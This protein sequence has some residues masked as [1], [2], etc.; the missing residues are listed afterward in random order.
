[1]LFRSYFK[2]A[3]VNNDNQIIR[4]GYIDKAI[5]DLEKAELGLRERNEI[6]DLRVTLS[7]LSEV[8]YY[9]E[10]YQ[11]S[12]TYYKEATALKDTI[13]NIE[14]KKKIAEL[15]AVK[16]LEIKEKENEGL[17]NLSLLQESE[18]KRRN[19]ELINLNNL[20]KIQQLEIEKKNFDIKTKNN[21]LRLLEKDK[22][23]K[24]LEIVR[25]D[26]KAKESQTQIELLNKTLE[27]NT[28][29]RLFMAI[30]IILFAILVILLFIFFRRKKKA[31][32][33]LKDK[34]AQIEDANIE[35]ERMNEDLIERG[36]EL[37]EANSLL[38][39]QR[40]E[41][42]KYS[43]E[44]E[45]MVDDRTQ[46]LVYAMNE[47]EKANKL[48]T[49]IIAN[50]NHEIRTPLNFIKGSAALINV[51]IKNELSNPDVDDTLSSL[52][53]GVSRLTTTLE[54]FTDLSALKSGNF[55]VQMSP[56]NLISLLDYYCNT[57]SRIIKDFNKPIDISISSS[58]EDAYVMSSEDIVSRT[59]YF[60]ID[61]AVKFTES[62]S[63]DIALT[64]LSNNPGRYLLSV[65]DTGIG[66]SENYK[67]KIF[68]PFTQ[69]DMS[70]TRKYEGIG[71]SLALAYEYSRISNFKI[72]FESE[73]GKGSKFMLEFEKFDID[74]DF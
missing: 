29:V 53:I 5:S 30:V 8:Y 28:A 12:M 57:F 20:Q 55:S 36:N 15:E 64:E 68:D 62:G 22:E 43:E 3:K 39:E 69:E 4:K 73:K 21:E 16:N 74:E 2:L 11:K 47:L 70:A 13:Y 9:N 6:E 35:L 45:V 46:D 51:L 44:L 61:N 34:N 48:K 14:T 67:D 19:Q 72:D 7:N 10:N 27:F 42:K 52:N 25:K 59:L 38:D 37:A 26:I 17:K 23:L 63:I 66:I 32:Q 49:E 60:I 18:L 31:N 56:F 24:E 40:T 41:L 71:L 54:L 50:M 33:E 65:V 1:M 58:I